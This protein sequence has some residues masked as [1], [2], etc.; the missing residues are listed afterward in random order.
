MLFATALKDYMDHMNNISIILNENFT[1]FVFLKSLFIYFA[2]SIKFICFYLI[3]FKWLTDFIELPAIFKHNYIAILEGK[4]LFE[5]S[6]ETELDKSFFLF[7]EN[8]SLNS[9]NFATGFLN[10]FFLVLPFSVPQIL[11]IRAFLINGLPAGI[12]AAMGTILG[13]VIFF[14]CILFG[15]E[16]IIVPFVNFEPLTIILGLAVLVNML[17]KMTHTPN[18]A[19]LNFS[20]K[21]SLFNI[22]GLNFIL[23]WTEQTCVFSYFGNLTINGS[24]NLIQTGDLNDNFFATNFIYLIGI[25]LGSLA[26]TSL[27]G[28]LIMAFRNF[29]SNTFISTIPFVTLNERIHYVIVLTTTILCFSTIPYYGFDYLISGPLGFIYED[30]TFKTSQPRVHYH[31]D[32]SNT[33]FPIDAIGNPLPFD[34]VDVASSARSMLKYEH[35]SVDSETFWKNKRYLKSTMA[36]S[37]TRKQIESSTQTNQFKKEL[38]SVPK[39]ET[40]NLELYQPTRTTK[41]INIDTLLTSLFRSDVYLG[42]KD[43]K[44]HALLKPVR[45]HRQFREKYYANPVYKALVNLDMRP[46]LAGQPKSYNLTTSDESD[47]FKRRIILQ[48][49]LNSIQ[50]YKQLVKKDTQSYAEKVYNQQFKG[51]LSVIR[52]FNFVNLN[53]DTNDNKKVLKFDQPRYIEFP[54]DVKSLLH[55]EL[56]FSQKTNETINALEPEETYMTLSNATPLYIGWDGSLRKFLIKT[57]CLPDHLNSGDQSY[58]LTTDTDFPPYFSF[59]TWSPAVEKTKF[60]FKQTNLKLPAL[61]AL[62]DDLVTRKK[63]V[64]FGINDSSSKRQKSSTEI[65]IDVTTES[66]LNRLPTYNWRWLWKKNSIDSEKFLDLGNAIPP[67]LDGLT[68][69]GV[70]DKQLVQKLIKS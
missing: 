48:N 28:F 15:L 14:G 33:V 38:L 59:Q 9:K 42:A 43:Y 68:W 10:S 16:F 58:D 56:N 12:C 26:W 54:N 46:F 11:A 19:I 2:N 13:Q 63:L 29:I 6:L 40:K 62:Q 35:Y 69:P 61:P 70:N 8:S 21:K 64:G 24:P 37:T 22:F 20:Q 49:Y 55:E 30:K 67:R 52:H 39:Y 7:L 66:F 57:P 31:E 47:L 41:E 17:Y 60:D 25:L 53:F 32:E 23:A 27:L 45:A 51:S 1:I 65:L 5:V 36:E 44:S 18:M 3:S 34:K 50:D 4:N